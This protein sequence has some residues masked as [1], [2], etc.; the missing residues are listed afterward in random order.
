MCYSDSFF[1]IIS[2]CSCV[3]NV[4]GFF[5]IFQFSVYWIEIFYIWIA[6]RMFFRVIILFT[7]YIVQYRHA[8]KCLSFLW[9]F[10]FSVVYDL[11]LLLLCFWLAGK[12]AKWMKK[13]EKRWNREITD[14]IVV[15]ARKKISHTDHSIYYTKE[16]NN[17]FFLTVWIFCVVFK[18]DLS[19]TSK[20]LTSQFFFISTIFR[21]FFFCFAHFFFSIIVFVSR[22]VFFSTWLVSVW[23]L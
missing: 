6:A 14:I 5:F 17:T 2:F 19:N 20:W 4:F 9:I 8:I 21:F 13:K 23:R 16:F 3:F 7:V 10:F 12:R 11:S 15:I 1:I 22:M 18:L